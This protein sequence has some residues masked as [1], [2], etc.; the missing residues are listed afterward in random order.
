MRTSNTHPLEIASIQAGSGLGRVGLT[1][2]PGKHQARAATGAWE[3]DL[4]VDVAAISHWGAAAVVT[5]LEPAELNALSVPSLGEE[6]RRHHMDW[7][8][9]PIADVSV[10][11]ERFE[12]QWQE[13]GAGLRARLRDGFDVLVHCKGGLGRA[14]MIAAR[15][16]VEL[17]REPGEAI[18][19]VRSVRP[20]AIE[21]VAQE[22]HV[23][24]ARLQDEPVPLRSPDATRN[25]ALGALVGLAV[26]DALGT[27]LEFRPRDTYEPLTDITGGGP[28]RLQAGE[29]TDDTAMALALADSLLACP[30][31][32]QAD[33]MARFWSWRHDGTYSCTGKCFDIGATVSAALNRWNKT[34]DPAAGSADPMSAGNGALMR[35]APVAL[36]WWHDRNKL[37]DVA[38][39]QSATTHQAPEALSAS[40]AFATML[41]EAISGEPRSSVLKPQKGDYSGAISSIMRGSWRG[42]HR[43][44]VQSSGYVA[45]SLEAALWAT[46]RTANFK[47]AVLLAANLGGDADTTAAITGQLAGALYGISAI[48]PEWVG[49]LAWGERIKRYANE[50]L[51][52]SLKS[53]GP[54]AASVSQAYHRSKA[55]NVD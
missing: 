30:E 50:L 20:G 15:L 49:R 19:L 52:E 54:G 53:Y 47:D 37:I 38:I 46:G 55:S 36:R 33:L 45:H 32:D 8:H 29:W 2:C 26:G 4:S 12:L 23:R 3:R 28:F 48:P 35:L 21:T 10:P 14:G 27:T 7:L 16:L 51:E 43:N 11:C 40:A 1:F 39:R 13:A 18:R 24:A 17:G 31:L 9:L 41:A 34:G 25:H 5:L 42:K 6:V 44:K 22:R